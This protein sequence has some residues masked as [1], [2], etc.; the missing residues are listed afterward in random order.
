MTLTLYFS[1]TF[2]GPGF[3]EDVG[4]FWQTAELARSPAGTARRIEVGLSL[5]RRT[6]LTSAIPASVNRAQLSK[7]PSVSQSHLLEP[8]ASRADL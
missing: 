1:S 2:V 5:S 4:I 3:S 7:A 6:A 8:W